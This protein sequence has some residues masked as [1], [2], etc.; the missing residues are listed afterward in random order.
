MIIPGSALKRHSR[1]SLFPINQ[2]TKCFYS[3]DSLLKLLRKTKQIDASLDERGALSTTRSA[4]GE[5]RDNVDRGT[6]Q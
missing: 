5:V 3:V 6:Y 4:W 1:L 2:F